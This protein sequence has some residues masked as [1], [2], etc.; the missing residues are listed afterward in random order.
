MSRSLTAPYTD[1]WADVR[2]LSRGGKEGQGPRNQNLKK[3]GDK[4]KSGTSANTAVSSNTDVHAFTATFDSA[5]L[6]RSHTADGNIRIEVYDSSATRHISPYR[7]TFTAFEATPPKPITAVDGR[8]FHATGQGTVALKVPNGD[9]WTTVML[10]DVLYAPDIAFA[11]ISVARADAAGYSAIFEQGECHIISRSKGR[12]V[13]RIPSNNGLFHVEHA[14]TTAGIVLLPPGDVVEHGLVMTSV[15]DFH[16]RMGHISPMIAERLVREGRVEGVRLTDSAKPGTDQCESCIQ[17]KIM[18]HPMPKE[19]DGARAKE[20]GDRV[21]SDV[22]GPARTETIGGKK[23]FTSFTNDATRWTELYLLHAKSGTFQA[24]KSYEAKLSTQDGKTVKALQSDRGGK[25]MSADFKAHLAAKGT[26]SRLTVHDTLQHNGLAEHINRTLLEHARAMLIALGLPKS[27]WG[28]AIMHATWLKNQTSTRALEGKTP[29]EVRYSKVPDLG[30]IHEFSAKVWVCIEDAGKLDSKAHEGRFI[31]HSEESKGYH[32][33]WPDK[34]SITQGAP[35]GTFSSGQPRTI[36][37]YNTLF[38]ITMEHSKEDGML[39]P[40]APQLLVDMHISR[41]EEAFMEIDEQVTEEWR[42]ENEIPNTDVIE[43]TREGLAQK[44]NRAPSTVVKQPRRKAARYVISDDTQP[45]RA[46]ATGGPSVSKTLSVPA[47]EEEMASRTIDP[48][49]PATP[50]PLS[51][52]PEAPAP[53]APSGRGHRVRKASAYVQ[54]LNDG[55]GVADGRLSQSKYPKGLQPGDL[56][57]AVAIEAESKDEVESIFMMPAL[58]ETPRQ[59][60]ASLNEAMQSTEWPKWTEAIAKEMQN[61]DSHG[62]YTL[63]EPPKNTNIVGSKFVFRIKH[64]AEGEIES[65]KARLVAQGFTQ[66]PGIDF[67]ETFAPVAKLASIR[68]ILT[69]AAHYDWE[70][71]QMDV[72]GVY[73]NGDLEE[74]IYMWQPPGQAEPGKEHLVCRLKRPLYG[75]KQSGRQFHKKI[76]GEL[77]SMGLT[78]SKVDHCIFWLRNEE[79]VLILLIALSVDDSTIAGTKAAVFWFKREISMHFEMSDLGEMHWIL[80]IEVRRDRDARTLSLSQCAYI[81]M[82][83]ARFNLQD[84]KSLTTPLDPG[85]VLSIHQCPS[86]P[87]QFEDMKNIPYREAIGSLMYAA[88]GTRPDIAYAVTALSQFMKNPGRPHWEAAKRVFRYLA[89]TRERWL[90][91]GETT[92]GVEGFSDADWGSAEHR[93]SISRYVFLLDGDAVSWSA[94]KQNVVALSSTEAEYIAITHAT[95]EALWLHSLLADVLHPD[96]LRYPVRL[97][98]DN[99]SAIALAKDDAYH[100]H[101]KHIDIRF[102]FIRETVENGQVI[103]QYRRT[104]DMPADIFTKVLPRIKVEHLSRLIGLHEN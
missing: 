45:E 88:L 57:G 104:E 29:Y 15:M 48:P 50:T 25:Y 77:G 90:T 103:L 102:H 100:A 36:W 4:G 16:R 32:V 68:L 93:H 30:N 101:T 52:P 72:K 63:V 21:H 69:L 65:Y 42:L 11:L 91:F 51:S 26:A 80:G 83:L 47:P 6:A 20:L 18:R 53:E 62:T 35:T 79:D 99:K 59:D 66:V 67:N 17:A 41:A 13:G 75:L 74:E 37:K 10:Q 61:L 96:I 58:M 34:H 64:N 39:P 98:S 86:T 84:A 56:M 46:R 8:A 43:E 2:W 95:K 3:D 87:R 76:S 78:R 28:E 73:L 14:C 49:T 71:H 1:R 12:I 44:R 33:Y 82:I 38:H 40:I 24:Y 23:Y 89:G 94:K 19:R 27:L 7:D 60:P 31:G 5:A 81:D 9:Q 97:H 55:S 70:L 22:W 85:T 54:R 92:D